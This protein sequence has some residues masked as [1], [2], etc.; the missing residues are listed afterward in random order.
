MTEQ[1]DYKVVEFELK[2]RNLGFIERYLNEMGRRGYSV[3]GCSHYGGYQTQKV[4]VY[5]LMKCL[6]ATKDEIRELELMMMS[7]GSQIN[8]MN[9]PQE[10]PP[11][12]SSDTE[13]SRF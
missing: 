5:T 9:S 7:A 3:V 13:E 2:S 4:V 6:T 8:Q 11:L 10:E 1:Y 12:P